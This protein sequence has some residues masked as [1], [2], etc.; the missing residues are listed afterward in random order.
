MAKMFDGVIEAVRF[1]NG[2]ISM[3]RV[4]ERR[5]KTF[6]DWVLLD[7]KTLLDRMQNGKAF[8]TGS[9]EELLAGTFT[10]EKPCDACQRKW[11][12]PYRHARECRP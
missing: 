3:V 7:R 12:R 1:K 11:P 9:R 6:S 2:Q 10:V 5:G 8:V 4:Y